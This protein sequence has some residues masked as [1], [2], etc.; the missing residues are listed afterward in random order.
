VRPPSQSGPVFNLNEEFIGICESPR[1]WSLS[2]DQ[3]VT[4]TSM[5][6]P[7]GNVLQSNITPVS[8][9]LFFFFITLK[10]KVE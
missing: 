6:Q 7:F 4:S 3:F 8:D 1:V 5:T 2:R 9:S 10:P